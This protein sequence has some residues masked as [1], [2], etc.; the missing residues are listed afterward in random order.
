M[1]AEIERSP[2]PIE[3]EL[4]NTSSIGNQLLES[5]K[6]GK[7]YRQAFVE[8][9]VRT[10]IAV[11]I[12]AIREQR[13]MS[14]PEL[15]KLMGKSPSWIFRLEDPNEKPPTISTLLAVAEAFDINLNISFGPFQSF[16]D[17]L[18]NMS[19]ASFEVPSFDEELGDLEDRAVGS[20]DR[21]RGAETE[22]GGFGA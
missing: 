12:K 7:V 6:T 22:D 19:P 16:L 21:S 8:E 9:A 1:P 13:K 2:S 10:S 3:S 5:F 11:Q 20:E 18:S 4:A 15:A 17:R 14:R